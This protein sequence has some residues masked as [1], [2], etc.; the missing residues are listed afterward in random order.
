M[1]EE[2]FQSRISF[3]KLGE[4]YPKANGV[5]IEKEIIEGIECY[6]FRTK[7]EINILKIII[8]LHGGCFVLGSIFSHQALVSHL[9]KEIGLPFLFVEYSVAPEKPYPYAINDILKVYQKLL[10]RYPK[11]KFVIMGDS[12]GAWLSM[13]LVSKI[14]ELEMRA[15]NYCIMISPWID[16]SCSNKSI[17]ENSGKDP[18]LTKDRLLELSYLFIGKQDKFPSNALKLVDTRFPPTLILVGSEEILLDDSKLTYKKLIKFQNNV[19][20]C[21][22]NNQTHVWLLDNINSMESQNAMGEIKSFLVD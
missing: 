5:N 22:Y 1:N 21:I 9:S 17:T 4:N 11:S 14:Y 12:A 13:V 20:L 7:E 2:I 8:Y 18:I 16:L 6:W 15:P 10:I 3:N 19:K